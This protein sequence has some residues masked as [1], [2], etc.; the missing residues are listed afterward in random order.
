MK[1]K[2]LRVLTA[3]L[4][5]VFVFSL[6][7]FPLYL[8]DE[9]TA[10]ESF[11]KKEYSKMSKIDASKLEEIPKPDRPDLAAL[12]DYYRTLDPQLKRVPRERLKQAYAETQ[13]Y[14]DIAKK[15][16][17]QLLWNN[18]PTNSGGRTRSLMFDPNDTKSLKV[19]AGAVTGGLWYN[20]NIIDAESQ[21]VAVNDFWDNLV[22]SCITYDPLN[23]Q[24][25]Y[26][27]TGESQTA[28]T[29][30]RE[31]SG[32]GIG[33]W[34]TLNGGQTWE[35]IPSTTN[36]AYVNDIVV[37]N[38]NGQSVVYAAVVSGEYKGE[39]HQ[40]MP[41]DGVFRSTD[42]CATWTQVLPNITNT[43]VPYSPSDLEIGAD[44]RLYVGTVGNLNSEGGAYILFSDLG[45]ENSW[46][47]INHF[48]ELITNSNEFN[49]PGRIMLAS[50]PSN[51]NRIYAIIGA[52]SDLYTIQG[53]RTYIGKHI[54]ISDNKGETWTE[55]S[56]PAEST[57][58]G[59]WAY[60][61]WHAFVVK[62]DPLNDNT[63]YI[64]GLDLHKSTDAGNTWTR[65]S[66]WTGMYGSNN[67]NYVHADQ[68]SIAF[69]PNEQDIILFANDGG[70][71]LTQNATDSE[72]IFTERNNN[73][74]T[75][76]FYTCAI[77]PAAGS[78]I[79]VGGLQD[80]GTMLYNNGQNGMVSGGDGAYCFIDM[81]EQ[82]LITS[83][84]NNVYYVLYGQHYS[85]LDQ[86]SSGTFTSPADYNIN[87]NTLYCNAGTVTGQLNDK[88]LRISG[89]PQNSQG[90]FVNLGT[91]TELP[92]SAVKLSQH[93][94]DNSQTMFVGT[95][96]G[97]LYKVQ[98]ANT[99]PV[100]TEI[101]GAEF[102][103]ANI[104]CIEIGNTEANI[105]VTFSNYGVSSVW[106]SNNGGS[107]WQAKEANLPDMPIRWALMHPG[108][109]R[110]VLLATE[111]G[112]WQVDDIQAE[113]LQWLPAIEGFANVRVDMLR[114]RSS[115]FTVL[116]ATHGRGM[117]TTTF[118]FIPTLNN[119]AQVIAVE[120]PQTAIC[121]EQTFT[122]CV[123]I[124]NMGVLPLTQLIVSYKINNQEFVNT[125][126]TGNVG[127]LETASIYFQP[128]TLPLGEY[129]LI[130]T[131][132]Q[133][134][135]VSDENPD[136]NAFSYSFNVQA[137]PIADFTYI[138]NDKYVKF[139]NASQNASSYR[140]YFG[141][142]SQAIS[143]NPAH[144][145]ASYG[146]Y[147][148]KLVSYTN[149]CIDSITYTI[150]IDGTSGLEHIF[151]KNHSLR[152]FPNPAKSNF[153]IEFTTQTLNDIEVE[154]LDN[155]GKSVWYHKQINV[156]G[157]FSISPKIEKLAKGFYIV[158]LKQGNNIYTQKL[159]VE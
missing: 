13:F 110:Q 101:G 146:E 57:M 125:T 17:N 74:S 95:Q 20:N 105:L 11:L 87:T 129:S 66:D 103:I 139:T 49:I 123:K 150:T 35:L 144:G 38:E 109:D 3:S 4:F 81:S 50:S 133:P 138:I 33:I 143:A 71:F 135:G 148:V 12:F 112:V 115:D 155:G 127:S 62:I 42:N 30:Y 2:Q 70:V 85:V 65:I 61:S 102:P 117:F 118:N 120:E 100:V 108:N 91:G 36:F 152:V 111:I 97:R 113:N 86:W 15:N 63:L 149:T 10:F 37:R 64:G 31:S 53:Y 72:I 7:F 48:N 82:M 19:W 77:A 22:I 154:I 9:R 128:I 84:Y 47:I 90:E 34:R 26:V 107:S 159:I 134:N 153:T 98:N 78:E 52:G 156:A 32:R 45:T 131:C 21:W 18:V 151:K 89:I 96:T 104:S 157:R 73:F 130:A 40:A 54:A 119:D 136:N 76:Q 137:V 83:V 44:N 56:M 121:G 29:T 25:F 79:Y 92:F 106:Y 51:A 27:G 59:N 16:K 147:D 8:N 5:A 43:S 99:T 6:F 23:T 132:S 39:V 122:P 142:G 114:M 141:D 124:R 55:I 67:T 94:Q 88:I 60:L 28:V 46:T 126:W 116:A 158:R 145:Y 41:S 14:N 1:T 75:L 58:T 24:I 80:N 140:W 69:K 68:H 93:S